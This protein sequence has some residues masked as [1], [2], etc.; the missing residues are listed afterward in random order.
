MTGVGLREK[1][2]SIARCLHCGELVF[3]EQDWTYSLLNRETVHVACDSKF[4][5]KMSQI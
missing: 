3:P 1:D 4:R 2:D 5:I